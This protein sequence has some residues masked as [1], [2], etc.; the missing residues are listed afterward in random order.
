MTDD[1]FKDKV[2]KKDW[3]NFSLD[4]LIEQKRCYEDNVKNGI[5]ID[6]HKPFIEAYKD[7][8]N[9]IQKEIEKKISVH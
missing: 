7:E 3:N 9:V 5:K 6:T 1:E 8:I 4:E 2:V